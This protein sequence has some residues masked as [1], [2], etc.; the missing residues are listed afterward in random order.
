MNKKSLINTNLWKF[1]NLGNIKR[2]CKIF[3]LSKIVFITTLFLFILFIPKYYHTQGSLECEDLKFRL[4]VVRV[5]DERIGNISDEN[6]KILL[7][8]T[9]SMLKSKFGINEIEFEDKGIIFIEDFFNSRKDTF[10]IYESWIDEKRFDMYREDDIKR[11]EAKME[12]HL[13]NW[14]LDEL[15]SYLIDNKGINTHKDLVRKIIPI[16]LSKAEELKSIKLNNKEFLFDK[17]YFKYHSFVYWQILMWS[18]KDYDIVLTNAPIINDDLS[19]PAI[20]S[21]LG[22][23]VIGGSAIHNNSRKYGRV[24]IWSVFKPTTKIKFF[25]KWYSYY[26]LGIIYEANGGYGLAHELGHMLF[27]IPDFYDEPDGCLM[28]NS[29]GI[30]NYIQGYKKL[31][32]YKLPCHK[33]LVYVKSRIKVLRGDCYVQNRE[34]KKAVDEYISAINEMPD[35]LMEAPPNYLSKLY[36]KASDCYRILGDLKNA[37]LYRKKS[38]NLRSK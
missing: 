34:F 29:P 9:S 28:N 21:L 30:L 31:R 20:H 32:A 35:L 19:E 18:E 17:K 27:Y 6:F 26:P 11:F 23:L 1:K 16:Y 37:N 13:K 10:K 14:S 3:S 4:S 36:R 15:K 7:Q 22:K 2:K 12:E 8:S 38:E 5:I 33:E 25:S 24:A